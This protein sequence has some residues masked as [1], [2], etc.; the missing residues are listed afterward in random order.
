MKIQTTTNTC[1]LQ[2]RASMHIHEMNTQLLCQI[3]G[4]CVNS[5]QCIVFCM[6]LLQLAPWMEEVM[7]SDVSVCC[8][9]DYSK[10]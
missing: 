8:L 7:F 5:T 3:R 6:L 9:L 4:I 2:H 1:G 10:F